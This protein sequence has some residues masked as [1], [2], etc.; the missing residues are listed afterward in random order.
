M[1]I[2]SMCA[3]NSRFKSRFTRA[4]TKSRWLRTPSFIWKFRVSTFSPTRKARRLPD[5]AQVAKESLLKEPLKVLKG[6]PL[7]SLGSFF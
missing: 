1:R 6:I 2:C 4:T 7:V 3:C 5:I